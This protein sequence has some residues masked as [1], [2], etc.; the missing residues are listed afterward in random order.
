MNTSEML[1][2][3]VALEP[4]E[5]TLRH[6]S[7][8]SRVEHTRTKGEAGDIWGQPEPGLSRPEQGHESA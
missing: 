1:V 8:G 6:C 4:F 5:A 2:A 3:A 7:L